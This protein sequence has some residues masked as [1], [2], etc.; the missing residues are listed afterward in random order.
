MRKKRN[1]KV[2]WGKAPDIKKRIAI[3]AKELNLDWLKKTRIYCFRSKNSKTYASAR[4]WGLSRIWQEAL[5]EEPAYVIEV[6]SEKFDRLSYEQ[7]E[8]VLIHEIVHIPRNFSGSLVP[9]IRR[10]K[11]SFHNKVDNLVAQYFKKR[12][13]F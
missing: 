5:G 1:A 8:K 10:G 4:I 2:E 11:R 3:L 9:H 13:M 6:I 12:M 7:Q